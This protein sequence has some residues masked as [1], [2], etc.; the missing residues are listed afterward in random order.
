MPRSAGHSPTVEVVVTT[1]PGRIAR[2]RDAL[3][4]VAAQTYPGVRAVVLLEGG[5]EADTEAVH[6]LA[7]HLCGLVEVRVVTGDDCQG[8][9]TRLLL[10]QLDAARGELVCMLDDG[11]VLYPQFAA[12]LA[13]ELA[14]RPTLRAVHGLCVEA[15]GRDEEH[16]FVVDTKTGSAPGPVHSSAVLYRRAAFQ[17]DGSWQ[18]DVAAVAEPVSEHRVIAAVVQLPGSPLR[19]LL[20]RLRGRQR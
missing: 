17:S 2:L 3:Y 6:R 13:P 18:G 11:D 8:D 7:H 15:H 20:R 1:R 9:R 10:A 12:V 5:D 19:R 16:G 4:S 14:A